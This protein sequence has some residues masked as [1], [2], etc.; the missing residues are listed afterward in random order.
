M[1]ISIHNL[2]AIKETEIDLK[3]LT[4]FVGPNNVGKTWAAYLISGIFG[5]Y[6]HSLYRRAYLA[7]SLQRSRHSSRI[8]TFEELDDAIFQVL[9][10]G[11]STVDMV[12]LADNYAERYLNDVA[13][14][15]TQSMD[16]YM[17][18]EQILFNT[19]KAQ[20]VIGE[21]KKQVLQKALGNHVEAS[22]NVLAREPEKQRRLFLNKKPGDPIL[23]LNTEGS[24]VSELPREAVARFVVS[25][26]LASLQST[27]YEFSYPFPTERATFTA[28]P[29]SRREDLI[30]SRLILEDEKIRLPEPVREFLEMLFR[31]D[32]I[33][34]SA[35]E[36]QAKDRKVR[37]LMNL[38]RILERNILAGRIKFV[39]KQSGEG[40][41]VIFQP[42]SKKD[43]WIET[44]IVSSMVKELSGLALY[45]R[46]LASP[47]ELIII[48]EPEMNLHPE[49]QVRLIELLAMMVNAGLHIIVTTHSPYIVDHL[50]NLMKAAEHQ[51]QDAIKGSFYLKRVDA[52]IPKEKVSVYMFDRGTARNILKSDGLIDWGTF[53]KVSDR[54]SE[55]YYEL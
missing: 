31:I 22:G 8:R 17:A 36:E 51:E 32:R 9:V 16:V 30:V 29:F 20:V 7:Q 44:S 10:Q 55:I 42:N 33:S 18:T 12:Q 35:R 6:G 13:S 38:A 11:V 5:Q 1:K 47:N 54:V 52:F 53:A 45:L 50:V 24:V 25:S 14:L 23:T 46:L 49:A 2:G 43:I 4:V 37:K 28:F 19:L 26:V 27:F 39:P 3:P 41:D 15:V 40:R 34:L 48:D 21:S